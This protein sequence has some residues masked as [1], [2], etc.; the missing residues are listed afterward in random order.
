[1]VVVI[2]DFDYFDL[3]DQ[4]IAPELEFV[5]LPLAAK[6]DL[7]PVPF[8]IPK[9]KIYFM[10]ENIHEVRTIFFQS[11]PFYNILSPLCNALGLI[12]YEKMIL[13]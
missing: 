2:V 12:K 6:W 9:R 7:P 8:V 3:V 13:M 11:K 1:M 5:V 4:Y 10:Y